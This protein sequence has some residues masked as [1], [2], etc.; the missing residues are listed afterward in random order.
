[1][2]WRSLE[3]TAPAIERRSLR[4]I[5]A[6]RRELIAKYVPAE[7]QAVHARAV[8]ELRESLL[9]ARTM[10]AGE[11]APDFELLN[12]NGKAVRSSEILERG[13]LVV[14]FFRGRWCPFCVGQMEAMNAIVPELQELGTTLV[15]ISP[16]TAHQSFL[17]ADQH[18][19]R[20]QLLSDSGNAVARQFGIVY[21]VPEYQ[22]EVYQRAFV[23]L[24]FVNG[25]SNWELPVPAVF[26]LGRKD[27]S[28]RQREHPSAPHRVG[29]GTQREN[30]EA[31][32]LY[33]S[34]NPDY[35]ERSEP[36]D[37]LN[38]LASVSVCSE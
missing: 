38:F 24:P 6:E 31:V 25:D 16:Q 15:G 22:Q 13:P 10:K 34:A 28:L 9:A 32:V 17:M 23:N 3:E 1:M 37:V 11:I 18:K 30:T 14:C 29:S 4:E 33:A 5:Y 26:I 27:E 21:R 2:K 20:F 19:L 36:S 35:T 8:G 12:Q 7:I